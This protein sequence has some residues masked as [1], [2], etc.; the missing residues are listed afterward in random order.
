MSPLTCSD[1]DVAAS[2][3]AIV[4]LGRRHEAAVA[5]PVVDAGAGYRRDD[6]TVTRAAFSAHECPTPR[7]S[8]HSDDLVHVPEPRRTRLRRFRCCLERP[9][10]S[11]VYNGIALGA[12][13]FI[14]A[15]AAQASSLREAWQTI[16]G[17]H[18]GVLA[19]H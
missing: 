14:Q 15:H 10:L 16:A 1:I 6:V 3:R 8:R 12:H 2:S 13:T 17:D 11:L 9:V 19:L 4:T 5:A 18:L 7:C